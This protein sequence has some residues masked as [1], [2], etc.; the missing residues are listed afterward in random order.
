MITDK[1][2]EMLGRGHLC[3]VESLNVDS[4]QAFAGPVV[5]MLAF[6]PLVLPPTMVCF[7]NIFI[8]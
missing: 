3:H 5:V 2:T 4:V 6:Q 1:P 7:H 8:S